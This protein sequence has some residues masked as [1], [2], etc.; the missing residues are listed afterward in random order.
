MDR[1]KFLEHSGD[2]KFQAF[3]KTI[4]EAFANA[5][6]AFTDIVV[7]QKDVEKT[8]KKTVYINSEN[9]K[10]LLYDFLEKVLNLM[11]VERFAI[12]EVV[13]LKIFNQSGK[14]VLD[15][16]LSG[17]QGLEKYDYKTEIKAVTYNDMVIEEKLD[18][19]MVQVVVDL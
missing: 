2:A 17:D 5:A 19:A 18:S 4:E 13:S 11:E 7:E 14:Y 3:G 15:A 10:S 8:I 6:I 1:Y 16:V 12:A 9:K